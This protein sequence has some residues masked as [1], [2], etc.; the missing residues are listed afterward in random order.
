MRTGRNSPWSSFSL[1]KT[2]KLLLLLLCTVS[3]ASA[4]SFCVGAALHSSAERSCLPAPA[5]CGLQLWGGLL[6]L[7]ML[8]CI[9]CIHSCCA[10]THSAT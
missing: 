8:L 7:T 6:K 3:F 1:S 10:M 5:T 9:G 4:P 2:G